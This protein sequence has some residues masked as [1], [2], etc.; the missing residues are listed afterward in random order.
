MSTYHH[1]LM[2]QLRLFPPLGTPGSCQPQFPL[3]AS[4]SPLPPLS[5]D[6]KH[7][8]VVARDCL[9]RV[10]SRLYDPMTFKC[11]IIGGSKPK[12][13]TPSVVTKIEQLKTT[14]RPC[15]CSES[16]V[17]SVSSINRI[18]R[19]RAA[20]RAACEYARIASHVLRP[21]YTWWPAPSPLAPPAHLP[22][23]ALVTPTGM[24]I[25]HLLPARPLSTHAPLTVDPQQ[26]MTNA[27]PRNIDLTWSSLDD[28]R[29]N[30]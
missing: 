12:V 1:R 7:S 16:H 30:D 2:D 9:Q 14:T 3:P 6:V 4:S 20:E 11:S 15:V 10:W 5:D 23:S 13:A 24:D 27:W 21:L 26:Q 8:M 28:S 25:S 22:A 19:N 17:P 18:L 29:D